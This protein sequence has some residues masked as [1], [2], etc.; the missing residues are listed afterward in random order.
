MFS[1]TYNILQTKTKQLLEISSK[2]NT[3]IIKEYLD[4]IQ[5]NPNNTLPEYV[6]ELQKYIELNLNISNIDLVI[7]LY[8]KKI[9]AIKSIKIPNTSRDEIYNLIY[10]IISLNY[11][12]SNCTLNYKIHLNDFIKKNKG[13]CHISDD[14]LIEIYNEICKKY[15]GPKYKSAEPELNSQIKKNN[16]K[17]KRCVIS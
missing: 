14:Y 16:K 12:I 11:N 5:L 3:Q 2:Y 4:L 7:E 1:N 17:H 8:V 10:S 15:Y 6:F 9:N 13:Y